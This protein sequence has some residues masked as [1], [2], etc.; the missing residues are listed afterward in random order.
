MNE[1]SIHGL[2]VI[3]SAPIKMGEVIAIWG[4]K[5]LSTSEIKK[6]EKIY[7]YAFSH[8]VGIYKGFFLC[9][10]F[11]KKLDGT[12]R[13][14]HS[15]DPNAGIK[16]QIL[17]VARRN[18]NANEEVCFDYETTEI[19]G[20]GGLPFKCKCGSKKCR[21]I[22]DGKAWTSA[23]FQRRNRGYF[24]QYIQEMIDSLTRK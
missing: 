22:I 14:N 17:L 1:S 9:N 4:G 11:S 8:S 15:C 3:A 19:S 12:E 20:G 7:P 23:I 16:G 6:L 18:I 24:S 5:I 13:M 2:G 10:S 21:L